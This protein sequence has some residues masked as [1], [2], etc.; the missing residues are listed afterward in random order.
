MKV[1][2]VDDNPL[3]SS[4]VGAV[5][6]KKGVDYKIFSFVSDVENFILTENIESLPDVIFIDLH[7]DKGARGEELLTL[8]KNK[9]KGKKIKYIA[10]TADIETKKKLVKSGFDDVI[11]KPITIEKLE[12]LIGDLMHGI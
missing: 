3:H 9:L 6:A 4:L 5:L 12:L 1:W 8:L 10:F 7:L 2:V 11:N